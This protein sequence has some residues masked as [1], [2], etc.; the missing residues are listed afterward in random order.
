MLKDE[1]FLLACDGIAHGV[2]ANI[3]RTFSELL[4]GIDLN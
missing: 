2:V 3:Q 1:S 4:T